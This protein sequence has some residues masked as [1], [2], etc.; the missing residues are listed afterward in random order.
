[1][2]L[3][4]ELG[5]FHGMLIG[6]IQIDYYFVHDN[7]EHGKIHEI[8]HTISFDSGLYGLDSHSNPSEVDILE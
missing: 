8:V 4:S 5:D 1:M 2:T 6:F 3:M 7:W